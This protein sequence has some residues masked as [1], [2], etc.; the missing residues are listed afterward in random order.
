[1]NR[2]LA[3][4]TMLKVRNLP[5]EQRMELYNRAMKLK[6]ERGWGYWKIAKELEISPP[7]VGHWLYSGTRP[8]CAYNLPDLT[9]SPELCYIIGTYWGDGSTSKNLSAYSIQLNAKDRDFVEEFVAC[10][11]K[12]FNRDKP[13]IYTT[14]K[15]AYAVNFRSKKL[16]EFLSRPLEE[17]KP[18]IE[19]FPAQFLRGFF[20]SEGGVCSYVDSNGYW[21][22]CIYADNTNLTLLNYVRDL[23]ER[24]FSIATP[25]ITIGHRKGDTNLGLGYEI[26]ATKDCYRLRFGKREDTEKFY[27]EIG[28][29]IKR[30]MER[31]AD[32]SYK[33]QKMS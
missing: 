18:T 13:S 27:R 31:L 7:T 20:D 12:I 25:Q 28:F 19:K 32:I 33:L 23:L 30:K 9:P 17:H 16:Y 5:L 15:N 3:S 1:M 10:L 2:K 8:D 14:A 4:E 6:K 29:S 11:G 26:R 22:Q 21:H 24:H